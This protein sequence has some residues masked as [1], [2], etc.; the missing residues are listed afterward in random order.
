MTTYTATWKG[1]TYT[2][3]S[4]RAIGWASVVR[5]SDG[6][7][8]VTSWHATAAA[9]RKGVLTGQQKRG[10]AQ[11]IDIVQVDKANEPAKVNAHA[12]CLATEEVDGLTLT[13]FRSKGHDSTTQD[14]K[15]ALHYD[16][17]AERYFGA[18]GKISIGIEVPGQNYIVIFEDLPKDWANMTDDQ[19]RSH[20]GW[21]AEEAKDMIEVSAEY[22]PKA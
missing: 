6:E 12:R 5:W 14:P 20:L 2:H 16:P 3:T 17:D 19:R 13:C 22:D 4:T 21:R 7:E 11:V 8:G 10:G 9:A 15:Q 18:K 1:K